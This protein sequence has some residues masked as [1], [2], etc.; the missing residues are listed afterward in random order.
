LTLA[1]TGCD[2]WCVPTPSAE[3]RFED[4]TREEIDDGRILA[5]VA[6]L[7]G[8]CFVGF[9]AAPTNRYVQFHARQGV[10]LFGVEI[11]SWIALAI[12]GASIGRIPFLG[13]FITAV[14]ELAVGLLL[15]AVTVYG[16]AKGAS[17]SFARIPFLGDGI[18]K[19]PF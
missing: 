17:G 10:I 14:A 9:A 1:S 19:V 4:A 15:L 3:P 7:P 5:A 18:E 6:Y 2:D 13:L 11:A 12:L 16:V 8:L